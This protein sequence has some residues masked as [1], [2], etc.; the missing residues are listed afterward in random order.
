[1]QGI[2]YLITNIENGLAYV[3]QTTKT[4]DQRWTEHI[5]DALGK[6]SRSRGS[7]LHHSLKKHGIENFKIE[8]VRFCKDKEDL[9]FWEKNLIEEWHTVRPFGYNIALGGTGVMHGRKMSVEARSKISKGLLGHPGA[10]FEHTPEA[11]AKISASLIGNTRSV[12]RVHSEETK[13]KMSKAH[14]G[15]TLSEDSRKKITGRPRMVCVHEKTSENTFP[16][17]GCRICAKDRAN[18]V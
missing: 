1:M 4:I 3:G 14:L 7:Y 18:R 9:D 17:G 8:L 12:G 10:E 13:E 6:H 15:K 2:I 16:S 5:Y 11:K